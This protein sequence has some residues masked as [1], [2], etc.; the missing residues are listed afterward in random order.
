[1]GRVLEFTKVVFR[2]CPVRTRQSPAKSLARMVRTAKQSVAKSA[3]N[4]PD[5][6]LI[7]HPNNSSLDT[8]IEI[9]R[10]LHH[11]F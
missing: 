5:V 10:H 2:Y 6:K 1:M 11:R 7:G 3:P 4:P 9:S 8:Q